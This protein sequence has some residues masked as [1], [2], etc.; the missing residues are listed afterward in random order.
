MK[1]NVVLLENAES[2]LIIEILIQSFLTVL[3]SFFDYTL[4]RFK[5]VMSSC[6]E[7]KFSL[8]WKSSTY[9]EIT[10]E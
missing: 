10:G 2:E 3:S 5:V 1:L 6:S 9:V 4:S 8:K 7:T